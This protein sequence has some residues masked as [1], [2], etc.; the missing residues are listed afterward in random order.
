VPTKQADGS[1]SYVIPS[2]AVPATQGTTVGQ[3]SLTGGIVTVTVLSPWSVDANGN[4]DYSAS[5]TPP[6]GYSP[7]VLSIDPATGNPT[8]TKIAS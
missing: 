3:S 6:A 5:N 7:A 1:I 2:G 8:V 4:V